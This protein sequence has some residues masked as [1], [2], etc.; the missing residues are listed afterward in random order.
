MKH[1]LIVENWRKAIKE[2]SP[3][4]YAR[5]L[6]KLGLSI[7]DYKR[8]AK[9]YQKTMG[10]IGTIPIERFVKS[11]KDPRTRQMY[12]QMDPNLEKGIKDFPSDGMKPSTYDGSTHA[13]GKGQRFSSAPPLQRVE[14]MYNAL[15]Q[16][17]GQLVGAK[18]ESALAAMNE[19]L[20]DL[21][22]L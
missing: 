9:I 17:D 10:S 3:D 2:S 1:K 15:R 19:L 12:L 20:A 11:M 5:D 14:K 7:E 21:R 13:G 8:F 16:M 18:Y 22:N 4:M 6:Q